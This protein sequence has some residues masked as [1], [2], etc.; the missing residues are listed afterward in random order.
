MQAA[1]VLVDRLV[2]AL[3]Q[4]SDSVSLKVTGTLSEQGAGIVAAMTSGQVTPDQ[5]KSAMDVIL[6]QSHLT[7]QSEIV[8]RLDQLEGLVCPAAKP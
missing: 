3:K 8:K 6:A 4:T 2:P 5:A 1:K 7:E